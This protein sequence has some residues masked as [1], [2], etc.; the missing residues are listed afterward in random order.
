MTS[1][2]EEGAYSEDIVNLEITDEVKLAGLVNYFISSFKS[3]SAILEL[4][5]NGLPKLV[6]SPILLE[7]WEQTTKNF[8][9]ILRGR[10]VAED[11]K[12]KLLRL[13]NANAS[14]IIDHFIERQR[15]TIHAGR[16]V[17]LERIQKAKN[18][19]YVDVSLSQALRMHEGNVRTRGMISTGSD[20]IEK[21]ITH[22]YYRCGECDAVNELADYRQTR[23]RF[24]YEIPHFDL[25][26]KKCKMG[27]ES[28]GHELCQEPIN[29]YR[30][31]LQDAETFND[32]ERLPVILL[33]NCTNKVA[34]GE[35]V[36]VTGSIH[37]VKRKGRI[38]TYVFVGLDSNS[39]VEY[40]SKK[41]SDDLTDS[42]IQE[43][44]KIAKSTKKMKDRITGKE[45]E[46][47]AAI[48][49][50]VSKF[51]SSIIG[52]EHVKKGLLLSA[53]NSGKDSYERK[54]RINVLLIG[55]TG[56]DKSALL[57]QVSD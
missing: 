33:D 19:P 36:V 43:F 50:L 56:L 51:A 30:I 8:D 46:V 23:P 1:T 28:Y 7:D 54:L 27:C 35:Q 22:V 20:K 5:E 18:A 39:T 3:R 24:A 37:R 2:L 31:E 17:K 45:I 57:R 29:A 48:D 38:L 32:L 34:I 4:S 52:L 47:N 10:G 16:K 41:E 12:T 49:V 53:A 13:L 11:H 21:M 26:E 25:Q 55:E 6:E 15:R 9:D 14:R 42:E 40:V 44:Q